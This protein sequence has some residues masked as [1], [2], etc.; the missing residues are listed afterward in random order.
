[1]TSSAV[2]NG[3]RSVISN[4][5]LQQTGEPPVS[6]LAA[7][8]V[9]NLTRGKQQS[10]HQDRE[11]FEQLLQIFETGSQ[12]ERHADGLEAREESIKLIDVVIKAGLDVLC[13]ENPFENRG[14]LIRQALRSLAVIEATLRGSFGLLH[15]ATGKNE[16][17]TKVHG[18]LDLWLVPKLLTTV[19]YETNEEYG[20]AVSRTLAVVLAS[21]KKT[22]LKLPRLHPIQRYFQ[23][24]IQGMHS[25][26][27]YCLK[28]LDSLKLTPCPKDCIS[29]VQAS[30]AAHSHRFRQTLIPYSE[31]IAEACPAYSQ[32]PATQSSSQ[33]LVKSIDQA[34]LVAI[35]S[36]SALLSTHD[37]TLTTARARASSE[38]ALLLRYLI[39][40]WSVVV[41][42][43]Q[44]LAIRKLARP[45]L[46]I[47]LD[48]IRRY[49]SFVAKSS[50]ESC[51]APKILVLLARV[52]T[53]LSFHSEP[54]L[55]RLS[56]QKPFCLV[57]LEV[58]VQCRESRN[59]C[60]VS[61]EYLLLTLANV[62]KLSNASTDLLV[63]QASALRYVVPLT[64]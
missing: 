31:T 19:L 55:L 48:T 23:G 57:L 10:K 22:R 15:T 8:L 58:A 9:N 6:T 27:K 36:L 7:Q 53:A 50:L 47:Y 39:Q 14:I 42:R 18:P 43:L 30:G 40:F 37:V 49:V 11:D 4:G 24:C 1:M 41:P 29:V 64:S 32:Y 45:C 16:S 51:I 25:K 60:C 17:D 26:Q 5:V 38:S 34:L 21:E 13:K 2:T 3:P 59:F 44:Q 56:L 33:I 28:D 52:T 61:S 35:C 20:F 62:E 46:A 12:E 63:S 54:L